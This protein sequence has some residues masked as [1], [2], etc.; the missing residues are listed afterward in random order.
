MVTAPGEG[1]RDAHDVW[2][3]V[4]DKARVAHEA[5]LPIL[6]L[7][8]DVPNFIVAVDDTRIGRRSTASR[9]GSDGASEVPRHH[10]AQIWRQLAEEGATAQ[11]LQQLSFAYALVARFIAGVRFESEPNFRLVLEDEDA[12]NRPWTAERRLVEAKER[13]VVALGKLRQY[14]GEAPHKPLLLLVTLQRY[15][16]EHPERFEH[17]DVYSDLLRPLL[18]RFW[19]AGGNV[20]PEE[21]FWRL[22]T[23]GIWAIEADDLALVDRTQATPPA[24]GALRSAGARGGF[25]HDVDEL[26]RA[27]PD[28]VQ[29][30]MDIILTEY[31]T[32]EQRR[33]LVEML[34]SLASGEPSPQA[35][36]QDVP[37]LRE[38]LEEALDVL[39]SAGD[40]TQAR[41]ERLRAPIEQDAPAVLR[42]LLRGY[43]VKGSAGVGN[44]ATVPWVAVFPPGNAASARSGYYVV[45]LFAADG[46]AVYASFNQA[47]QQLGG[48]VAALMKRAL[49][50]R[51]AVGDQPGQL[52]EVD[53]A[54]NQNLGRRY[55]AG[56]VYAYRY[57]RGEV[58]DG[59]QLADDLRQLLDL[60]QRAEAAGVTFDPA[61]EPVHLLLKWSADREP[62]TIELHR[63]IA[64][65]AGSV[66]WGKFGN[67]A[68]TAISE[69]RLAA[70]RDQLSAGLDTYVFFHRSGETWRARLDQITSDPADV[71][72]ARAPGYYSTQDC[73][74]F[75]RVSQ[76]EQLPATWVAGHLLLASNPDPSALAGALGNQA[77]PLLTYKRWLP[78]HRQS[79]GSSTPPPVVSPP[80]LT[81]AWLQQETLWTRTALE[82]VLDSL[83]DS[84]PQVLLAG[85]PGTGKTWVAERIA[86]YLTNDAPLTTRTVQFHP[87]YGYEE[88]V[89]GLRP[90]VH[91]SALAF[92]RVDGVILEIAKAAQESDSPHVLIVD[93]MNRANIP[94][95]FGELLHQ[96][97][98]RDQPIRLLYSDNFALPANVH[99]IGTMNTADRSIRSID[100]ALRRR[101]DIFNCP[102]NPDILGRYYGQGAAGPRTDVPHLV[103]GFEKLNE[104]LVKLLDRH[105]TIGHS[106]FMTKHF[107]PHDLQRVWTHQLSPLIEEYFFDQP[108]VAAE[109]TLEK[110][111]PQNN[112]A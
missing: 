98:Y 35:Q 84:S 80:Q 79:Q 37:G 10:V 81:L 76:F 104:E 101:F 112:A 91:G 73:N 13:F 21:P 20:R 31:F 43:S 58:P 93:E 49:D 55:A 100:V 44:P 106:F 24:A 103:A 40:D 110:F 67:P 109:F 62:H 92:E 94:R 78:E 54:T 83:R 47:A 105:H 102:P 107:A 59:R 56:N 77:N 70:L 39:G 6:T 5:G 4:R 111:W 18:E 69:Q 65:R 50:L 15:S 36:V 86:R 11:V 87:S 45:Y 29:V 75:V 22:K 27:D 46:S 96:L 64:E 33:E 23:S 25:A 12:A 8:R 9:G 34:P 63:E 89:E 2:L 51:A 32:P 26:L 88:F 48:G 85:P 82:E 66:W 16:K 68:T 38:A 17:F 90:V 19:S 7:A 41:W 57:L 99:I 74:L 72:E 42:P 1:A 108:D 97:E 14:R 53:L 3:D 95:V 30:A 71:D 60:Q 61:V 28:V 52:T